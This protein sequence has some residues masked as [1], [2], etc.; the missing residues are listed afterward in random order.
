[1]SVTLGLDT[2]LKTDESGESHKI[3]S[4][5]TMRWWCFKIFDMR[6]CFFANLGLSEIRDF[7]DLHMQRSRRRI[8]TGNLH[9]ISSSTSSKGSDGDDDA[10]IPVEP[11][12]MM[13]GFR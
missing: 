9:M 4:Y 10:M 1:V 6:R 2:L 8:F 11:I 7:Q 5:L 13:L 12:V 3:R